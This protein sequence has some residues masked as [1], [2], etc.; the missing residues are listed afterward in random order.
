MAG[1]D[2]IFRPGQRVASSLYLELNVVYMVIMDY[3]GKQPKEQPADAGAQIKVVL[4][5]LHTNGYIFGDLREPNILF[6]ADLKVKLID[7]SWSGR[8]EKKKG[9]GKDEMDDSVLAHYL[10]AMSRIR[11]MWEEEM[12]PLRAICPEHDMNMHKRL[13]WD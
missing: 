11:G 9:G 8:Y 3:I 5:E 12:K 4:M 2:E 13:K 6:S 7:F 10:L 1:S